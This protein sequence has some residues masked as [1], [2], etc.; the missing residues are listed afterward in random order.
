VAEGYHR[1][2]EEAVTPWLV[3]DGSGSVEEVAVAVWAGVEGLLAATT[4]G[5]GM[6]GGRGR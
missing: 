1:L 3:V 4:G 2:A 6:E 5:I